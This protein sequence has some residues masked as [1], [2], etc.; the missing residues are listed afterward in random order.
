MMVHQIDILKINGRSTIASTKKI[1]HNEWCIFS[2]HTNLW[3]PELFLSNVDVVINL[4]K[5]HSLIQF[6]VHVCCMRHTNHTSWKRLN[7]VSSRRVQGAYYVNE[8]S[9]WHRPRPD[10]VPNN[11]ESLGDKLSANCH[12]RHNCCLIPA[13]IDITVVW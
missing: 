9:K 4:D 12:Y 8:A 1:Y 2:S 7:D 10:T 6:N 11:N 13:I 5:S 3:Y